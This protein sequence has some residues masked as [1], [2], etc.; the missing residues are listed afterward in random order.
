MHG[1]I[2]DDVKPLVSIVLVRSTTRQDIE[3]PYVARGCNIHTVVVLD[4]RS[5]AF[6]TDRGVM[7]MNISIMISVSVR[8]R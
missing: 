2:V 5:G 8:Y 7:I 1:M 6:Y 4:S 3:K